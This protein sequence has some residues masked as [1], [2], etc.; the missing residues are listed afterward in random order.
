MIYDL[1]PLSSTDKAYEPG[2]IFHSGYAYVLKGVGEAINFK[3]E[4][5]EA[6]VHRLI[7]R[8]RTDNGGKNTGRTYKLL[9]GGQEIPLKYIEGTATDIIKDIFGGAAWGEYEGVATLKDGLN[10][11][12]VQT[13][14]SYGGFDYLQIIPEKEPR[15]YSENDLK[16]PEMTK[17]IANLF[18][19][20]TKEEFD[21]AVKKAQEDVR[22]EYV[23]YL[24]PNQVELQIKER[25]KG[26][27]T[28]EQV[29]KMIEDAV[30]GRY[31]Q[32]QLDQYVMDALDDVERKLYEKNQELASI[33]QSIQP[34]IDKAV[35][36]KEKE[37]SLTIP[38]KI[39][40][41]VRAKTPTIETAAITRFK[42]ELEPY[43]K[44]LIE[45]LKKIE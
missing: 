11:V 27:A 9:I 29:A 43:K 13:N 1:T 25:M 32:R 5:Y 15:L 16:K 2:Y 40:E 39:E 37:L 44:T 26:M 35:A 7:L 23:G 17:F 22:K 28:Q 30:K 14:Q 36:E 8:L 18:G 20:K 38:A 12:I 45:F 34:T 10:D 3:I 21:E 42:K 31:T 41:A 24:N 33:K 19:L 6:G 4:P